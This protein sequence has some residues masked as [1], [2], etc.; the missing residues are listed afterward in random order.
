[1]LKRL[2]LICFTIYTITTLTACQTEPKTG[3][4][5]S[6]PRPAQI[7]VIEQ[8]QVVELE[9]SKDFYDKIDI[10]HQQTDYLSQPEA[11]TINSKE[12]RKIELD[13]KLLVDKDEK[14]L[15]KK[16]DG[17]EVVLTIPFD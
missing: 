15:Q 8:Q 10:N 9:L 13:G 12:K 14:D 16:I 3:V 1:M 11:V 17:G 4:N 7:D 2:Q 6:T 5:Q